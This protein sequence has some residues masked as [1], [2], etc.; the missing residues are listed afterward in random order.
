M[1]F[2]VLCYV[3]ARCNSLSYYYIIK[4]THLHF[5]NVTTKHSLCALSGK[6]RDVIDTDVH[7]KCFISLHQSQRLHLHDTGSES[8]PRRIQPGLTFKAG[9]EQQASLRGGEVTVGSC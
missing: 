9:A 4:L 6:H 1:L 8:D 7:V 2:S 3:V 5:S